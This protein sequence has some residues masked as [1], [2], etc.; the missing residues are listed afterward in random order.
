M[1]GFVKVTFQ[2]TGQTVYVP[3]GETALTAAIEAGLELQTPCG[4]QGTCGSCRIVFP[5]N[6]P[7][8]TDEELAKLSSSEISGGMRLACRTTLQGDT[9]INLPDSTLRGEAKFLLHG[10]TREVELAPG[11]AK[12]C[13]HMPPPTLEDQRSDADRLLA[14]LEAAGKRVTVEPSALTTLSRA[15]RD[16]GYRV[17][18]VLANGRVLAVEHGDTTKD[19]FAVAFDIGTTTVVG[20]LLDL[21]TGAEIAVAA[22]TNPQ[23]SF[24]DDVVSRISFAAEKGGLARLQREIVSCA[25]EIIGQ[26]SEMAG[27]DRRAVYAVTLCGNTTMNHL[28]LGVDPTFVAQAPYVAAVR[29]A[30]ELP[31]KDLG[32]RVNDAGLLTTLPNVAGFVGGDTVGMML[33]ADFAN[34]S[35]LR[36]AVDIGT[37][38]EIVLGHVGKLLCASTAAG[39]AFEGAR[40]RQGMRAA[41]GAIESVKIENG[42]VAYTTIGSKP[43]LGI[44]GTGLI[45]AV[46]AMLDAG[47]IDSTGRLLMADE[48][49]DLS[50]DLGSRLV[51]DDIGPRF[52]IARVLDGAAREVS[53]TQ[54]DV[55]ELQLAKAAVAAGMRILLKEFGATVDDLDEVLLAGAFGNYIKE[56]SALRIGLFPTLPRERITQIG[57]AAGTGAK[58]VAL[59][60]AL[61]AEAQALS[62]Q[63][64]Y[65][66]LAGRGDFLEIFSEAMLFPAA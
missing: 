65:V 25:N 36:L 3:K 62:L 56:E 61:L 19:L 32:L 48:A 46:A 6:A 42:R 58:L 45:D 44:C 49:S 64:R 63:V 29:D 21:E 66:E 38:G 57:N 40:I 26:L 50:D 28:F 27:I 31:A 10:I 60:G 20:M 52:V 30:V 35:K 23:V 54:R 34:D 53:L 24:G 12:V 11:V 4:G 22:R 41:D 18:A 51:S 43:A 33:A 14:A 16:G 2:P 1:H 37:N 15:L 59:D 7:K 47:L 5:A 17:T 8:P 13:V 39:P 9:V 55:R